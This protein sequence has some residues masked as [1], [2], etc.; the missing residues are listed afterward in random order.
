MKIG[1]TSLGMNGLSLAKAVEKMVRFGAECTELNG[2]PG[3]HPG[4]TWE[5]E[6]D[7]A[8]VRKLLADAG[9]VATSL[10]GYCD[11]AR[12]DD[13]ALEEQIEGFVGYCRRAAR[14]GIPVVR[15]FAGDVKEGYTLAY[16]EARIIEAFSELMQRIAAVDVKV[17]IENHGQLANDGPF[18]HR[19]IET[20]ASPKLGMTIDTGNFYHVGH[21]PERVEMFFELLAP[22]TWNV[23]IKDVIYRDGR[24]VFVPAGRGIVSLPRL[25]ALLERHGYTGGVVS[26]YEGLDFP[27]GEG[28]LESVAYLRG[29][30][31]GRQGDRVT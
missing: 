10:G 3:V 29:L 12:T 25:Y 15:A 22:Y 20:V 14:L 21:P 13:Q 11:F 26:E 9:I 7:E 24:A 16:F 5:S 18:L 1:V 2:R 23:H 6:A 4:L 27:Y 30:R 8:M 31:D 17:A 19:L 28:T